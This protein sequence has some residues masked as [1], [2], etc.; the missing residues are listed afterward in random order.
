MPAKAGISIAACPRGSTVAFEGTSDGVAGEIS[1]P[2]HH[3][4]C[5]LTPVGDGE[6]GMDDPLAVVVERGV[7][8]AP[9]A[10]WEL[11]VRRAAVIGRLADA[12]AVG[13]AAAHAA[14][15]ELGVSRRQVYVLLRR[16]R[17]GAGVVSDLIRGRSSGGRGREHLPDEVEEVIREILRR[18]T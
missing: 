11:A 15:A 14:A 1:T 12:G 3:G 16:W 17:E 5:A 18:G 6:A 8:T 10:V 13:L 2:M 9:D 4:R 7:L